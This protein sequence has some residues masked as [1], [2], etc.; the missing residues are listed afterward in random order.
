MTSTLTWRRPAYASSC[1]SRIGRRPS[2]WRSDSMKKPSSRK[3]WKRCRMIRVSEHLS[4]NAAP[5]GVVV[6][7]KIMLLCIWSWKSLY[8]MDW[9]CVCVCFP[10]RVVCGSLPDIY[11]EKLLGF[12]AACLEKSGHLQFYMTWAQSLLMLHGQKLKNRSVSSPLLVF[13]HLF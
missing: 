1:G 12:V 3:C 8:N 9:R 10:V 7:C 11:V 2:F 13:I 4:H 5:P 6:K